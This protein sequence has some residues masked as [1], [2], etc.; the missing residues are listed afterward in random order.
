MSD[1]DSVARVWD[2]DKMHLDRSAAIALEIKKILPDGALKD[3]LEYG[4][5]TGIL[6]FLLRDHFRNITLMDSSREMIRVC[7]EK[8]AVLQSGNITPLW[9][10]LETQDFDGKFDIIFCQM[11]MHHVIEPDKMFRKFHKLLNPGGILAIADLYPEDGS[12][13]G[14]GANVHHGFNPED[15][16]LRIMKQGYKGGNHHTCFT[17]TRPGGE[18]YP[19]FFH[20]S[21]R[22]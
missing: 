9:H 11:V 4:A 20:Y 17:I 1:F 3:A 5:G 22:V 13:H 10:D 2:N 6:S 12:F 15:L 16:I 21:Y 8:K 19:V 7:E 18:K 14:P